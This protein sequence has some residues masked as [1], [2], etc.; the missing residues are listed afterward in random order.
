MPKPSITIVTTAEVKLSASLRTRLSTKLEEYITRARNLA[1]DTKD[2]NDRKSEL[3]LLFADAGEYEALEAGVRI[4]TS[5]GEV[6]MKIV[7]GETAPKLNVKKLMAGCFVKDKNNKYVALTPTSIQKFYDA[8]K[9]KAEYLG[10]W[11]PGDREEG[12][13]K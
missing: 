6:P 11:I 12:E 4:H 1:T 8:G 5:M 2:I 7:K 3:E 9:A 13:D 10:I